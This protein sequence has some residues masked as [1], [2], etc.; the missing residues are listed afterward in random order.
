MNGDDPYLYP[1]STILRNKLGI[2]DADA[3]ARAEAAFVAVRQAGFDV[4]AVAMSPEGL[5]AIHRELFQDVYQWAGEY[6]TVDL[7]KVIDEAREVR[8]ERA[9][10]VGVGVRR[11]FGELDADD[12][13]RGLDPAAFAYRAA[14]YHDDLNVLHPF[15]EGNGRTGRVWLKALAHQ[16]G[17]LL[18]LTRID[19]ARWID[20]A[21]ENFGEGVRAEHRLMTAVIR[22]AIVGSD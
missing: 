20:A 6:R 5:R 8:F 12:R 1:G 15:R 21:S 13:L 18:D 22:A 14:V 11:F 16:A 4:H 3:L 10:F 9:A 7:T 2:L 19:P 17:H